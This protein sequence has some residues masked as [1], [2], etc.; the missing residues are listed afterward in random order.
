MVY[1]RVYWTTTEGFG[2]PDVDTSDGERSDQDLVVD[3]ATDVPSGTNGNHHSS[4][5][6]ENGKKSPTSPGSESSTSQ[7]KREGSGKGKPSTPKPMGNITPL[8][9]N[10]IFLL[11][12]FPVEL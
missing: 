4:G 2:V 3:D 8:S 5:S 11:F 1:R 12:H 7:K 9:S 10:L 6:E